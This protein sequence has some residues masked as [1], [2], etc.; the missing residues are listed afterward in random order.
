MRLVSFW[1]ENWK[2]LRDISVEFD[3]N[4]PST[5]VVGRNGT[6]KSNLIEALTIVFRDLDLGQQT[7]FGYRIEY[8]IRGARVKVE[9]RP[10]RRTPRV[11]SVNGKRSS[12][13]SLRGYTGGP[14]LLPDFVFG[15]YSGPSNRLEKHFVTHQSIFNRALREGEERPLRRFFYARPEHSQFVLLAFFLARHEESAVDLLDKYLRIQAFE[16]A[17]FVAATPPWRT[18]VPGNTRF[19]NARGTVAELLD[20]LFELATAPMRIPVTSFV[21]GSRRTSEHVYLFLEDLQHLEALATRYDGSASRLFAAFESI[22]AADLLGELRVRVK[23]RGVDGSV[24][25]RELSEGEQQLLMVLG[26]LRFTRSDES[27]FLL[28]E[29]DT[30][31]NPVWGLR[32]IDMLKEH[33]G[34]GLATSQI[35]MASHDPLVIA[36]LQASQVCLLERDSETGVATATRPTVD[37]RGMGVSALL[38]SEIYG[39]AS[40]LDP[41]TYKKLERR[42]WLATS[43]S[44]TSQEMEELALLTNELEELDFTFSDRDPLYY[45][46]EKAM[47]SVARVDTAVT[48]PSVTREEE[49]RGLERLRAIL[50]E[51]EAE[52]EVEGPEEEV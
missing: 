6:G 1:V 17:L 42:R 45:R 11:I 34:E 22:L 47:A 3:P 48:S 13:G 2:N 29:P 10:S 46:F 35:V 19:W 4:Q 23:A 8:L 5:V 24:T 40:E 9:C 51:D 14:R 31:L 36:S 25:F 39:L 16:S 12:V 41:D 20:E 49:A 26:L 33:S 30:H 38:T 43:D 15:Y 52:G 44:L 18:R 50:A 21:D 32:Y 37:P 27:L 7:N 28:D